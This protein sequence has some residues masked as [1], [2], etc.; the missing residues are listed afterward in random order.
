MKI[1]NIIFDLDETL[2]NDQD[3]KAEAD[4]NVLEFFSKNVDEID[5]V[6]HYR[7]FKDSDKDKVNDWFENFLGNFISSKVNEGL[8]SA[9]E[10]IYWETLSQ[11]KPYPDALIFLEQVK[12]NYKLGIL[13]DGSRVKQLRK[14]ESLNILRFFAPESLV[15]SEDVGEK[16]PS[17]KMFAA[18]VEKMQINPR[19]TLYIGDRVDR[20]IA[21]GNIAGFKT[22]L[23]RRN[24]SYY[25]KTDG[26]DGKPHKEINTFFDLVGEI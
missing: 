11:I 4:I 2:Y 7:L 20:D 22:V 16:K 25:A 23:L 26:Q 9:A 18:I 15:F 13:S 8:I 21:G 10:N 1:K 14:M 17:Q 3:V 19:E 24:R 6:K 5:V 12:E